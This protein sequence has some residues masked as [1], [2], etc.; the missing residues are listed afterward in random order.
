MEVSSMFLFIEEKMN[1][2]IIQTVCKI[3]RVL[4]MFAVK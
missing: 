3:W 2:K 4:M 1:D